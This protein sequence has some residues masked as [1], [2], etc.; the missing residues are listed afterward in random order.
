MDLIK[1]RTI[2][3][4]GKK[5]GGAS[6]VRY[7]PSYKVGGKKKTNHNFKNSVSILS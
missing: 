7:T 2:K 3:S 4:Y 5:K 6:T 1:Y